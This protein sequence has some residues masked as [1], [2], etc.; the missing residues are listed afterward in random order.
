MKKL[1]F[2]ALLAGSLLLSNAS[3]NAATD[4]YVMCGGDQLQLTVYNHPDLSS[5]DN[6]SLNQYIVRP[7][8]RL[9][10]PLIGDVDVNGKTVSQVTKE[11]AE[12]LSEY[13]INPLVYLSSIGSFIQR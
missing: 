11:I 7:D 6:S 10:V 13:I 8:G 3:A 4:E 2:S 9:S 1:L 5:S 12:R